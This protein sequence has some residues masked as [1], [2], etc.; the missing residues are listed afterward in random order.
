MIRTHTL[1]TV[2]FGIMRPTLKTLMAAAL[3]VFGQASDD[4]RKSDLRLCAKIVSLRDA[5]NKLD[6]P[7]RHDLQTHLAAWYGVAIELTEAVAV[8]YPELSG[9]LQSVVK[10]ADWIDP[11]W[12]YMKERMEQWTTNNS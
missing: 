5:T 7:T 4:L 6:N 9:L 12:R 11:A 1:K 2:P 10:E 3:L 8:S